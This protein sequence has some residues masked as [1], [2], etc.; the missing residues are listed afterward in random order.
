MKK[1]NQNTI[2]VSV[3]DE[4][5]EE[6]PVSQYAPFKDGSAREVLPPKKWS[7]NLKAS[8][9]LQMR[10]LWILHKTGYRGTPMK[11]ILSASTSDVQYNLAM[12]WYKLN[13]I[14]RP[15]IR[16]CNKFT[17]EELEIVYEC[18]ARGV[19]YKQIYEKLNGRHSIRSMQEL[20]EK[21]RTKKGTKRVVRDFSPEEKETIKRLREEEGMSYREIGKRL[22]RWQGAVQAVYK[23]Y[24]PRPERSMKAKLNEVALEVYGHRFST[25]MN[26]KDGA[27]RQKKVREIVLRGNSPF[28]YSEY[29]ADSIPILDQRIHRPLP[30]VKEQS[31]VLS[32]LRSS[33]LSPYFIETGEA[34][35]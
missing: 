4:H 19:P 11:V 24:T 27:D 31:A 29:P 7:R 10:K 21:E 3:V 32:F 12:D 20:W 5:G 16:P 15:C 6:V 25:L 8:A 9:P 17:K 35:F 33:Y 30:D 26:W 14:D 28:R 23:G 2:E 34:G 22:N 18:R 1:Y 13:G